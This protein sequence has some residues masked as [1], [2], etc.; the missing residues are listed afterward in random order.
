MKYIITESKLKEMVS[1]YLDSI[2][3][4]VLESSD[5]IYP[6]EV[7]E[8]ANDKGP[9]FVVRANHHKYGVTNVLLILDSFQ[10]KLEDMF[11]ESTR[12]EGPNDEP[13]TLVMDWF[14]KH[15]DIQVEDY[16]FLNNNYFNN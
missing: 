16:S 1:K 6:F 3:W 4:R 11:G 8:H 12:G 13:N 5:E 10:D 7:Y 15:F 9:T 2:D 14:N